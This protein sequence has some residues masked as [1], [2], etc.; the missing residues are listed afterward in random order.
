MQ[1]ITND[2]SSLLPADLDL[3]HA[4]QFALILAA[5]ALALGLVGKYLLGKRSGLNHCVSSAVGI[6]F[7][8]AVTIII[9]IFEPGNLSRFLSP[10]P[11]VSLHGEYLLLFS[12]A[13]S[14]YTAICTEVLNMIILAFLVNLLDSWIP[15]G[16]GIIG[17]YLFRFLTVAL[18][19]AAQLI[20]TGLLS[21]YLPGVLVAYAPMLLVGILAVMVLLSLLKA[22][23]S[24][25]LTVVNPILGGIYTFFFASKIGRM[26]GRAVVTTVLLC[27]VV[28]L[29]EYLGYSVIS[30]SADALT[31]YA[32]LAAVLL[33]LWYVIGHLL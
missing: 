10:L 22:L 30:I 1:F 26:L 25:V 29:L 24:L 31:G 11:F 23:L 9:Y 13:G 21:Q 32:P 17:W 7:V 2:L 28:Y 14:E 3:M 5:G 33:V 15:K 18:A 4:M 27:A 12:F 16:K 8:Y 20:V 19:M 6:L